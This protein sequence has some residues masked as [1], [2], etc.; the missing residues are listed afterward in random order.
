MSA[1]DAIEA[2]AQAQAA[3]RPAADAPA[4]ALLV[5]LLTEELPP[6]ALQSL[7]NSFARSIASALERAGLLDAATAA[8]ARV[9][10][11]P[12]RMGVFLSRVAPV[13]PARA[14]R[15]KLMPAS[16]GLDAGG[17][18]SAA[19][20]RKL[21]ALGLATHPVR[22]DAL[23]AADFER[24]SDGKQEVLHFTAK[25]PG[26]P[27]AQVLQDGLERAIH[28]LP[29]PRVMNYQLADGETTVQFVRPA[30]G[31]LALHGAD[32]VP[33]RALGLTSGRVTRGHR[34]HAPG[35]ITVRS[36]TSYELQL[37]DEGRVIAS[38][39]LRRECIRDQVLAGAA[40]HGAHAIAPD[41]LLDE[42]T[43][44]VE[45]PVVLES[46][47]EE[48]FLEVPQPCLVLTMQQNQKYFALEDGAGRL[49]HRFL[50]VSNLDADDPTAIVSGNARVVR[51][52]LADARFF[53]RQDQLRP[54]ESRLEGLASVVYHNRLGSQRERI[55][56][57]VRLAGALAPAMGVEAGPA[58]RAALLAKADLAT[59]MVG[60]FPELQGTMG[61]IYARLGGEP[62]AVCAAIGQHYQPRGAGDEPPPSA[63]GAC[64][65]LADKLEGLAGLM[66]AGERAGGD[67]DPYGLRRHALGVLRILASR[68]CA[69]PLQELVAR[70]LA[71]FDSPGF[72]PCPDEI[73]RFLFDRLRGLLLEQGYRV[74]E[75]ESVLAL[76]PGHIEQVAPRLAA[77]RAFLQL[78]ESASLAAANKRIANILRKADAA[79]NALAG[80]GAFD[81]A[82]LREDAETALARALR[83]VQPEVDRLL[84]AGEDTA[85]LLALAPL[86]EPVDRFFDEVLVN[87]ED[88][89]LRANRL[90]LLGA[91]R[92]L[93]NRIAE[94]SL[95]AAG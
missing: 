77:V 74:Q 62:E 59:L 56:R 88:P 63:L 58:M 49:L 12:R 76:E 6:R 60:E 92:A 73:E 87:A 27:L 25:L 2:L 93:M 84:A 53:Y 19:L 17:A 83:R 26:L 35:A 44:L 20:R 95:L 42:V 13:S 33:L 75:V 82:L 48:E 36:A 72:A 16:I 68:P 38:F 54:L 3:P 40:V 94:I 52:R 71:L 47:F 66:G 79:A 41:D 30:H 32:V 8:G 4:Q 51:A 39:A 61:A 18:V 37:H 24:E 91:L 9:F 86:R 22:G 55:S 81:D 57:L 69:I 11:T 70:A 89:A 5:E 23:Q 21:A 28:D 90:G 85:L 1:R 31:L 50:L 67:R 7:A 65:A 10:A 14:Q 45:W 43:A 15:H 78:P 29:I 34:F 64:V 46:G 80:G